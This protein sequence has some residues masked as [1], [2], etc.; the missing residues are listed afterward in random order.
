V[1]DAIAFFGI[2]ELELHN[3]LCFCH[4]GETMSAGTAAARVRAVAASE[5]GDRPRYSSRHFVGP[6]LGAVGVFTV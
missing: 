2:S 1:G 5:A 3:V 4:Y 6:E